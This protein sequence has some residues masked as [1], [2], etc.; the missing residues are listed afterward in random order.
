VFNLYSIIIRVPLSIRSS[1]SESS[2]P[3]VPDQQVAEGLRRRMAIADQRIA[4]IGW[5]LADKL[6]IN[7]TF[8][9][10]E[11]LRGERMAVRC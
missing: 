5:E 8:P 10:C 11:T 4:E 3:Q 2:P 6:N 7:H 1:F 9:P